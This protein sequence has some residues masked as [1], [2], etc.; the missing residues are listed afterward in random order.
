MKSSR[1][2]RFKEHPKEKYFHDKFKIVF[3]Q[4]YEAKKILSGI[5]YGWKDSEQTV[6]NNLLTE[7]EENVC[8]NMITWLG[9]PVGQEFLHSCGFVNKDK[10]KRILD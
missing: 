1:K 10:I 5:I 7:N 8:L 3:E 4:S 6:P 9:S 2:H